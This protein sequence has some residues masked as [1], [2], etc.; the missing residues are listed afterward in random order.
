MDI[1]K[2][3]FESMLAEALKQIDSHPGTLEESIDAVAT[4]LDLTNEEH[5]ALAERAMK[6]SKLVIEEPVE[7][8]VEPTSTATPTVTGNTIHFGSEDDL[9]SAA[10]MLMYKGCPWKTKSKDGGQM[11]I[12]F[13][14]VDTLQEAMDV[15]KRK[16][17]FV[18]HGKRRVGVIEFD[19]LADYG[20]VME[21][22]QKQRMM[23][24]CSDMGPLDEDIELQ[25]QLNED[26]TVSTRSYAAMHKGSGASDLNVVEDRAAR[27]VVVR[28]RWK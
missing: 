5:A 3:I 24:E 7:D 1:N 28:K 14:D 2:I 16:F 25:D 20:K 19:N 18:E 6:A 27:A 15:L 17:D 10:G 11:L 26:G 4:G 13:D 23:V 8:V 12:E 21:F 9:D 22:I